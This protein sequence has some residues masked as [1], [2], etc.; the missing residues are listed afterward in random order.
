MMLGAATLAAAHV[1]P[2]A[3]DV[4][5][6][7]PGA[8]AGQCSNP[9]GVATDF[10][11]GRLFVADRG[12]DRINVFQASNQ[13]FLFA[14]GWDVI[15]AG[16]P[17]DTGTG[18]EICTAITGCQA[19]SGGSGAGQ[20][21][22]PTGIAVDNVE[23]SASRHNVYVSTADFRWQVF[24]EDGSFVAAVG[25]GV[26]TGVASLETCTIG[27]GCQE[28]IKGGGECQ[29]DDAEVGNVDP[30]AV[31]PGGNV[32][33]ADTSGSEPNF[34][35][36]VEKFS[37]AGAC[38]DETVLLKG[39]YLLNTLAVDA[40]ENAFVSA[41]RSGGQELQKYDLGLPESKLCD[42]DPGYPT[43]ALT[44][45]GAGQL[46]AA[47][48]EPAE[49]G[50]GD[51]QVITQYDPGC[52]PSEIVRRF[53]YGKID[54]NLRGLA[55]FQSA[56]GDIFASEGNEGAEGLQYQAFPPPG[57]IVFDAQASPL[58]SVSA[59]VTAKVNPEG[60][61][62]KYKVEY[63]D[64][65]SFEA[66]GFASPNTRSSG[67]VA[68]ALADFRA[69]FVELEAGCRP[70]S[71]QAFEEG[72]CLTPE[73]VYRFRIVADNADGSAGQE[74][75]FTTGPPL[76]IESIFASEVGTDGA[77]VNAWVNPLGSPA[78]GYFEYVSDA[79]Y[80]ADLAAGAGHDGFAG[81][82]RVP[83]TGA[84]QSP[85]AFGAGDAA[86]RR[87][88][89]LYPLPPGT[90]FHYRL[91]AQDPFATITS[92]E[93]T[94]TTFTPEAAEAG[95]CPANEAFRVGAS[96]LLPD[97]RA[98]EMVSPLDKGNGDIV[99]LD[100]IL[101]LQPAVLDQSATSGDRVSYGSYRAFGDAR[102]AP[103]TS[104]YLA[105][106]DPE[107]GWR[108]HGIS[109]A[110]GRSIK[111]IV[112]FDF[113][114]RAFSDDLCQGWVAPLSEP[115][116]APG[117]IAGYLNLYH[118]VD[119]ECAGEEQ[120][121]AL[122]TAKPEN[123]P[124]AGSHGY[125]PELQGHSVDGGVAV[126]AAEDS[127]EGTGAPA[128][129]S[130]CVEPNF[131]GCQMRAYVKGEGLPLRYLCILPGGGPS[132]TSCS[133]G[134]G[135]PKGTVGFGRARSATLTNAVSADGSRV[136]WTA[137]AG[138][139]AIYLRENPLGS[140]PE[141]SGP[142]SPCT[143]AVSATGEAMTG[144]GGT[145]SR[146]WT[147]GEDGSKAI[148]T[149]TN[150]SGKSDLYEFEVEGQVTTKIA[151]G[152]VGVLGAG[153]D[154]SRVYF[155]STEAIPGSGQSSEGDEAVAGKANL[156]FHQAGGG[157]RFIATLASADVAV[158][159]ETKNSSSATATEPWRRN[160][161]VSA[162]GLHAAFMSVAQ[163][164][165]A[166]NTDVSSPEECGKPKGICD[167]EVFLYDA[168][169]EGGEGEILCASCN[170]SGAR[171][172]GINVGTEAG[173]FWVAGQMPT[174]ET[175]LYAPRVL[176][177]DGKRLFFE[178]AEAL[179]PRDTNG[180]LDVYEWERPGSGDCSAGGPTFAAEASG[181]IDL[182]SSGQSKRDAEF[183][184]AS[185]SGRDVFFKTLSSLVPSDYG[186]ID[187]YDARVDGGFPEPPP[188]TPP[189]EGESCQSPPL[190]P[191]YETS[192]TSTYVGPG[193]VAKKP[194]KPKCRKGSHRVTKNGK[195]RCVKKTKKQTSAGRRG[196]AA[197]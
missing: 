74:G 64:Q 155:A 102:S 185:S 35:A 149:T 142:G 109:P 128:Q 184:D 175:T 176:A 96:R 42:L 36:R 16:A 170:P 137:A 65:A 81:A 167:T 66:E 145:K 126:F 150:G 20:L 194:K 60:Q 53:G 104:Q 179:V 59:T 5:F 18:F 168:S 91:V 23:G 121:Q 131:F 40:E 172:A 100:Q 186:L 178:S 12:N 19:G 188:A 30:I 174:F 34:V 49:K 1:A 11:T 99:V 195:S 52:P 82:T 69:H 120:Y 89:T 147:A 48:V 62:T 157:Y 103:Y 118:R 166:D 44:L 152:V 72:K 28:G 84:G 26:D 70:F 55:V 13:N 125:Q 78:T 129:P 76:E 25:W 47:Q 177:E 151:G 50:G 189:C 29:I 15:P 122:S 159:P 27:S 37:P 134:S 38:L 130:G 14:F 101:T 86:L 63:V 95:H 160:G 107:Q 143:L 41:E 191:E 68:L 73:M 117:G 111:G 182:I 161:R 61:A 113:E 144:G 83:D 22:R 164:T 139:G 4:S 39:N 32:F 181:C 67:E 132:A 197:R 116:L 112:V 8:G 3:A 153:A 158:E 114:F 196:G 115:V 88:V 54:G 183:L 119:Q 97:C 51:F 127:L 90:T 57:P 141:C 108:T 156:Y 163:L 124:A 77:T 192:A 79:A 45:D 123:L 190:P 154:A 71:Q 146:F 92:S 75:Q 169:A 85:L 56:A 136:F 110:Q 173:P 80:Q 148:F 58:R 165:G 106:R 17:G 46:F 24:K 171:P 180:R 133:A 187:V 21:L 9:R 2:A 31:G 98:Y 10:Q 193:N 43:K 6:C 140:G 33:V 93:R 138:D 162:D 135:P 105:A 87:S 94:F 7:P